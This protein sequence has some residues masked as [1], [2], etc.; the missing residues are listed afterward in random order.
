MDKIKWCAGKKGGLSLIEPNSDL[1]EAYIKKAE[2]ALESMRVNTIK[3]WKISTAYYTL[4]FSLYSILTKIGIK[5]EIHSCTIEF[6]KRF[7]KDYFN[8]EGHR[9][10][11]INGKNVLIKGGGWTDDIFLADT[12]E[13]LEAQIEY[14]KHINLNTIRL[15]GFWGKDQ[16]LYDLCDKYG[17]LVMVGWSCHW[18]HEEYLGKPVD[19]KYG[20]ILTSEDIEIVSKSFQDQIVWLRNHPSIFVWTVGSDKLP[21]PDLEKKYVEILKKYDGTRNYLASTGGM[22]SEQGIIVN[23]LLESDISGSTGVKMLGPYAYTPPIY[24]HTDKNLGGAYG[25]NTE[26]G[27]GAQVPPLESLKKMI[28]EDHLWHIDDYWNFHCAQ[29][30][31][32]TLDRY[33]KAINERYGEADSVE[34]FVKKAQVINYELMRPMFEAFQANK[35]VSTGIIQWMLN[36]A[37]PKMYW[38]LY[39]YFLMPNGAFYGTKKACQPLHLLYRYGLNDI[40][41]VNDFLNSAKNLKATIRIFD[42]DSRELF[43]QTL[44]VDIG[45]NQSKQIFKLPEIENLSTTYFLDLRLINS[46]GV[47]IDN[48][49]YW[50]ST[51]PDVLDYEAKAGEWSFYT[52]SKEYADFTLLNSLPEVQIR[53]SHRFEKSEDKQK[54]LVELDNQANNIAFFIELNVSGKKSGATILP[55]FWDDNYI[56]L[57]PGE[58]R[59]IEATFF[60]KDLKNDKPE[61]KI[62]GWNLF[63]KK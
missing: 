1:A 36:T 57:L 25:F 22:G 11:K 42:I 27:P 41:L 5:C 6:A 35:F 24:W 58:K 3:D 21:H 55:V 44:T 8:E 28:P 10:F 50:L 40:F 39:D 17:I 61:L 32:S 37:W 56:S 60:D 62:S 46:E 54:V 49:F 33:I 16:T 59:K 23:T 4:Y 2:E 63:L 12:P 48:N 30:V 34:E 26:T 51:K 14:V 7:L 31:F 13:S 18:E 47:E 52:P 20:G 19:E 38:Q 29:N 15:E 43:N 45:E 9:A 53:V